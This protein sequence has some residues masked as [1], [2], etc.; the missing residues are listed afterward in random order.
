MENRHE[1]L[2]MST[3]NVS[4]VDP[5]EIILENLSFSIKEKSGMK[6]ILKDI[7]IVFRPG[8]FSVVLG[9]SGAGKSTLLSLMAGISGQMPK[10]SIMTGD[11]LFNN[12]KISPNKT[13]KVVGFVF[14]DDVILETMTVKEAINMSIRL[15][16]EDNDDE[17]AKNLLKRMLELS[18]L[19]NVDNVTIGSPMR[20]GISGGERKRTAIAMELVSNPSVLFLDEPT[21]GLDTYT[22]Y[23]ITALLRRLAK[24][25]GRTVVATLHQPS[26][27]IFHMIDDLYVIHQGKLVYGGPAKELVSYFTNAGY[28]FEPHSNPLD[29]LFM[30]ILNRSSEDEFADE[31]EKISAAQESHVTLSELSSFYA[32]SELRSRFVTERLESRRIGG[33]NQSMHRFRASGLRSFTFLLKRDMRN[34][35][36]NPMIIKIK[37]YQTLFL[38]AFTAAT[39]SNTR[40]ASPPALF[41][42]LAGVLFFLTTN[43]FF[44]SF[45][46]ILPVFSSEKPSFAREHA[47]GYY[48]VTTYFLSKILVELPLTIF[49]PVITAFSVY[50]IIGLR[51]GVMH[52]IIFLGVLQLLSLTAFSLGLFTA[53][54]F[55]DIAVALPLS[56][57][58][59]LPVMVYSGFF[60]NLSTTPVYLS[61]IQWIS[62]MKYSFALLMENEFSGRTDIGAQQYL[63]SLN[64]LGGISVWMNVLFLILLFIIGLLGAYLALLRVVNKNEG[65]TL[66]KVIKRRFRK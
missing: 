50:F 22:A 20:K 9:P 14:Q 55:N 52:F 37:L 59:I 26:S 41:Q 33:I 12:E 58:I 34:A 43:A 29:I 35:L 56:I 15:R 39:F 65:S 38:A 7:N 13:R 40:Y 16:V 61:W 1:T 18:Q 28:Y 51:S 49:F 11:I 25:H 27:E 23:R 24:R 62:P 60:V 45:Q 31:T 10:D 42:N 4:E 5:T 47:Q 64:L 32:N 2:E 57:V 66:I 6:E 48:G 8:K 3:Q 53:S 30:E 63:Q 44:A 19:E 17:K 54:I 21:S 36:R 46:N